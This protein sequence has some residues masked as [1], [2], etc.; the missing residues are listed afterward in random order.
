LYAGVIGFR[1]KGRWPQIVSGFVL[2]K[3]AG[4]G[5]GNL[6][7]L[8]PVATSDSRRIRFSSSAIWLTYMNNDIG[9]VN[10]K[11]MF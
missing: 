8:F 4:L 5:V 11:F 7:G 1:G 6:T 10:Q 3:R 9:I 2:L